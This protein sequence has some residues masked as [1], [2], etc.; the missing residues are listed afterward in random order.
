MGKKEL[1]IKISRIVA[2][3]WMHHVLPGMKINYFQNALTYPACK[4]LL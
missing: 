3:L 1:R 2:K 4:S